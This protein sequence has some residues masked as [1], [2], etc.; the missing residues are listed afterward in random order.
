MV[1]GHSYRP[2]TVAIFGADSGCAGDDGRDMG[3][4]ESLG[5]GQRVCA[6]LLTLSMTP[7]PISPKPQ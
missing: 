3:R 2:G 7:P 6:A 5:L 4:H 1:E